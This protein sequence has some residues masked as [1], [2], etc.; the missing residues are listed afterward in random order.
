LISFSSV[1]RVAD[2]YFDII[3]AKGHKDDSSLI[4]SFKPFVVDGGGKSLFT[5]T[6]DNSIKGDANA[7]DIYEFDTGNAFINVKQTSDGGHEFI[8][9]DLNKQLSAMLL[10]NK[11]FSICHVALYG[12]RNT[13][14]YGLDNAVMLSYAFAASFQGA[15]LIHASLIRNGGKGYPFIA[16]SGTGKSTHTGMWMYHIPGSDLMNDDNPVIRIVNGIPYIYGSPWSG[17]TPCYRNVKAPLGAITK[18]ERDETNHIEKMNPLE[19][20]Y[21]ILSSCSQ[22][23]W[24]HNI[25]TNICDSI[26]AIVK[27]TPCYVM[28]CLPDKEAAKVCYETITK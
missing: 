21:N 4:P 3:F 13:R 17:K 14:S 19:A 15:L 20:F 26:T 8:I 1:Y 18:I 23:R 7:E 5:I 16:K 22:M 25:Y 27:S 10:A 11:D 12:D 2:I 28:H 24:D 6:I 9:R